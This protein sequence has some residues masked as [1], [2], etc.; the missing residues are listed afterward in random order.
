MRILWDAKELNHDGTFIE[1]IKTID[2]CRCWSKE[3]AGNEKPTYIEVLI[4]NDYAG[5][6]ETETDEEYKNTM[7]LISK[8]INKLLTKG[9]CK[10]SDFCNIIW[11]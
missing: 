8:L 10:A 1:E 5:C 7:E 9:Y 2:F 4:D 11:G 3:E 6:Y